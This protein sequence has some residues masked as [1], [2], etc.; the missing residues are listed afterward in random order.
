MAHAKPELEQA[1]KPREELNGGLG[2]RLTGVRTG[3]GLV[4]ELNGGRGARLTGVRTGRKPEVE[5][6]RGRSAESTGV[7]TN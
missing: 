6:D 1:G 3:C 5:L 2:A 4:I 7:R